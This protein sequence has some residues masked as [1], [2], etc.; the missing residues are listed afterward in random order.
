MMRGAGRTCQ[1]FHFF[2]LTRPEANQRY[3]GRI[4]LDFRYARPYPRGVN[5]N[6]TFGDPEAMLK[7]KAEDRV[8]FLALPP[9]EAQRLI[10]V[11]SSGLPLNAQEEDP[12][13]SSDP[14]CDGV[15]D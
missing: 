11:R 3:A 14:T 15:L 4:E 5:S 2:N 9:A 8:R 13:F 10:D 6:I 7:R 12:I 1:Q